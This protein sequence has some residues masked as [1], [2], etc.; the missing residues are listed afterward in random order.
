M[1]CF[2]DGFLTSG[3]DS[4]DFKISILSSKMETCSTGHLALFAPPMRESEHTAPFA[5]EDIYEE[6][7]STTGK[8][9]KMEMPIRMTMINTSIVICSPFFVFMSDRYNFS[10]ELLHNC[11]DYNNA[12]ANEN[13]I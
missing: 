2:A 3:F 13:P 7:V 11:P 9:M 6:I 5:P 10:D 4:P 12:Y 1:L 8:R